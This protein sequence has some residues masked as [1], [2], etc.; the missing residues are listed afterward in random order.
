MTVSNIQ[1]GNAGIYSVIVAND[2]SSTNV[3]ASLSVLVNTNVPVLLG[4]ESLGLT[5][6]EVMFSAE[7]TANTATNLANYTL[8]GPEGPL[9][10]LS[11][12]QDVSGSNVVLTVG[13]MSN[14]V[15]YTISASNLANVFATNNILP[16]DSHTNFIASSFARSASGPPRRLQIG[17]FQWLHY[18][19]L[20]VLLNGTNDQA[21][22]SGQ[23]QTGNFDL[24]V[25]LAGLGAADVWSEAGLMARQSLDPGSPF[26]GSIATPGMSGCFF[27]SRSATNGSSSLAGTF[28]ANDPNTWLRLSRVGALF[29]GY[30]SYD[31][32]T[33]TQLGS[34]SIGMTDP[35]YVGLALT[36]NDAND[37]DRGPVRQSR[38]H[39]HQRR[40]RRQPQSA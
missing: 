35:I 23:L 12:A 17:A 4:A 29:T 21:G 5:G 10:L 25:C 40:G 33:W 38:Q 6:V 39:A 18:F 31:G 20:G 36:S 15:T 9:T 14:G 37:S 28:P 19:G 1:P 13:T 32:Q 22:F 8:T 24:R 34:A 26:A 27:D 16:P 3:A 2:I 7:I 11:A 30:A